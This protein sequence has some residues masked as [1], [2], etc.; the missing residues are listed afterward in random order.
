M[1]ALVRERRRVPEHPVG[2]ASH[3]PEPVANF[4]HL[5]VVLV[6]VLVHHPEAE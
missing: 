6:P 2:F 4:A 5:R 1:P 3:A